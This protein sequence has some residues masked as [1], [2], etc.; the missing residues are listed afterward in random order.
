[1][2]NI[3]LT[4]EVAVFYSTVS[5]GEITAEL[6]EPKWTKN[7]DNSF[8]LNTDQGIYCITIADYS[9]NGTTYSSV[10]DAITY[11]NSL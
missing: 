9:F 2:T 8:A 7:D 10:D 11:L 4:A 1:M 3:N 6:Y 5:N